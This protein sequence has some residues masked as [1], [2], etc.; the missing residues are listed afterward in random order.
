MIFESFRS[1]FS[2]LCTFSSILSFIFLICESDVSIIHSSTQS[3]ASFSQLCSI[4][5][6][7]HICCHLIVLLILFFYQFSSS[8]LSQFEMS[9]QSAVELN[10]QLAHEQVVLSFSIILQF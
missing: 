7:S 1:S 3:N 5:C 2:L 8:L 9:S 4:M 6:L 10:L